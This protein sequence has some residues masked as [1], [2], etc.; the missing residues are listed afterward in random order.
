MIFTDEQT[1][2]LEK[3]MGGYRGNAQELASAIGALNVGM[4]YGWKVVRVIY[5]PTTYGKYQ[6]VLGFSFKDWCPAETELA[7]RARGYQF[8][9]KVEK[10]WGLV[11]GSDSSTEFNELR[12]EFA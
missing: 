2:H 10:F 12:K 6:R 11:R 1:E 7:K 5:S 8:A 9:L 3:L 4:L